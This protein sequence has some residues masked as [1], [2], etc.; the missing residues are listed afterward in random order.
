MKGFVPS[1][2]SWTF[3]NYKFWNEKNYKKGGG[4]RGAREFK[5]KM[6]ANFIATMWKHQKRNRP[7]DNE[8]ISV[9]LGGIFES[10]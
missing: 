3:T 8:Q 10:F 9:L 5:D 1:L 6:Q 2:L 4:G 7:I